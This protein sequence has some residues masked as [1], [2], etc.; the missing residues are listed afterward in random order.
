MFFSRIF[1]GF[2]LTN[3]RSVRRDENFGVLK[4]TPA[5]Y[6]QSCKSQLCTA[7]RQSQGFFSTS[8]R[9][10]AD[11]GLLLD[12]DGGMIV[13]LDPNRQRFSSVKR[14]LVDRECKYGKTRIGI[15]RLDFQF[16]R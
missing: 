10:L 11:L 4:R 6:S 5:G 7:G 12:L 14:T 16:L 1:C 2:P 9:L 3:V 15:S 13:C 8:K